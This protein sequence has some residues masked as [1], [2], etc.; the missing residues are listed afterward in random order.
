MFNRCYYVYH[1]EHGS[2]ALDYNQGEFRDFF[3]KNEINGETVNSDNLAV[4]IY[5]AVFYLI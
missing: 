3:G 4:M 1:H 2:D 5:P